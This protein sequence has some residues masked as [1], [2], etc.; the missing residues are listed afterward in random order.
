MDIAGYCKFESFIFLAFVHF[1]FHGYCTVAIKSI[2]KTHAI[3][4]NQ[5]V[6]ILDFNDKHYLLHG[7]EY[8]MTS[9]FQV[10]RISHITSEI[11]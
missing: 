11:K 2:R 7:Y 4:P 5:L 10:S 3:L 1:T 8:N 9:V 6:D